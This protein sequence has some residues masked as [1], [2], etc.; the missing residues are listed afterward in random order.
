M[1]V[2]AETIRKTINDFKFIRESLKSRI[3]DW[4]D[5]Y[6]YVSAI[7]TKITIETGIIKEISIVYFERF[8]KAYK[9]ILAKLDDALNPIWKNSEEYIKSLEKD[10][11]KDLDLILLS[12]KF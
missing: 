2:Q 11:E 9:G 5:F 1:V 3:I 12:T 4:T 6:N 8:E 10:T 7:R